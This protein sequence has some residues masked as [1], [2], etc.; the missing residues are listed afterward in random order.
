MAWL[1]AQKPRKN[2]KVTVFERDPEGTVTV[3]YLRTDAD[4]EVSVP[5]KAGFD[6]LLDSVVLRGVEPERQGDAVW[7]SFWAALTFSVRGK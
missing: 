3:F 6:Y 4:G 7:E 1:D 5:V 2:A